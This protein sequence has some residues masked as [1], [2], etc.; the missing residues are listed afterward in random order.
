MHAEGQ[1]LV[2]QPWLLRECDACSRNL[3]TSPQKGTAKR[4]LLYNQSVLLLPPSSHSAIPGTLVG[5]AV[6]PQ[7][8][9]A[10]TSS[11]Q[12]DRPN[13]HLPRKAG[14][15]IA[16]CH[17]GG[18]NG[19][20]MRGRAGIL[21]R[22]CVRCILLCGQVRIRN[23]QD[24]R[25][26]AAARLDKSPHHSPNSCLASHSFRQKPLEWLLV[27]AAHPLPQHY[28]LSVFG[29]LHDLSD[30]LL[31]CLSSFLQIKKKGYTGDSQ[32]S[33]GTSR[34]SARVQTLFP[35]HSYIDACSAKRNGFSSFE[36]PLNITILPIL[37]LCLWTMIKSKWKDIWVSCKISG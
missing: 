18:R 2:H 23:N 7:G 16:P 30:L 26:K 28:K 25:E 10:H 21:L 35:F 6:V 17:G 3:Q 11:G 19:P 9:G 13:R 15:L 4:F 34:H 31:P 1:L 32:H 14:M 22:R 27:P 5:N 33:L 20:G 8:H 24:N 12:S 29:M 37:S 36:M